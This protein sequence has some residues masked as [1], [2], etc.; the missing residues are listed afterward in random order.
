[1]EQI[2]DDGVQIKMHEGEIGI[3]LAMVR[4][5]LAEQF[6]HLAERSITVVR[7]T[8]TVNAIYRLDNDL[9]VRFTVVCELA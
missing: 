8:G 9:C 5:L 6:P 1:M 3:D 7:S 4:R 2:S